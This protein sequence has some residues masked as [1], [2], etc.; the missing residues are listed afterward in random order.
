M[1]TSKILR[2]GGLRSLVQL[3]RAG[4]V[5]NSSVKFE[6]CQLRPV[7]HHTVTIDS[8]HSDV[9]S[10]PVQWGESREVMVETLD[11]GSTDQVPLGEELMEL[12]P[13]V[14]AVYPRVDIIH[15]NILWQ[16]DYNTVNY[17][18]TKNVQ[19][20]IYTYGG[21]GKPWQQ[22]GTGRA[23][24]GSRRAPQWV[25]GA[26]VHGPRGPK[27]LYY[28]LPYP[29]RVAGLTH[30]LSVKFV[31]DDVNV[32]SNLD[33]SSPDPDYLLRLCRDRGWS[34][35]VLFV[36]TEDTFPENITAAADQ[37]PHINLMPVYGLNVN[38]MILHQTLVLTKRAAEVHRL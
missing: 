11:T 31:Q 1:I 21:G 33:L 37:I 28:M 27:S 34:A 26:K 13:D 17:V 22:K 19:E 2:I 20:M 8:D 14:W 15:K 32:V 29:V 10:I 36:D 38:S 7:S 16:K 9:R 23:R 4:C 35:S 6:P 5:Q 18:H 30:S 24:Q 12:H 25:Q 3:S